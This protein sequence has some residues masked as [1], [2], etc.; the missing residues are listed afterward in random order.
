M[1]KIYSFMLVTLSFLFVAA[2]SPNHAPRKVE[3]NDASHSHVGKDGKAYYHS[4]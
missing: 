2:C 1:K 3:T 4:H